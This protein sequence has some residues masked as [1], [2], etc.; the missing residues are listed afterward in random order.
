VSSSFDDAFG[1][2]TAESNSA[3]ESFFLITTRPFDPDKSLVRLLRQCK[4]P[5][6]GEG[7]EVYQKMASLSIPTDEAGAKYG[8]LDDNA[9]VPQELVELWQSLTDE[10]KKKLLAVIKNCES[11]KREKS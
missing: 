11:P 3:V 9:T 7:F 5:N 4:P 10:Q 1:N 8:A 2:V 6:D